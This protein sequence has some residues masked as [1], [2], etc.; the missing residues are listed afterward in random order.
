MVLLAQN[1]PGMQW[2]P[3]FWFLCFG[4]IAVGLLACV[5]SLFFPRS[6]IG[7]TTGR[8]AVGWG[9]CTSVLMTILLHGK[10]YWWAILCFAIPVIL[11]LIALWIRKL[12]ESSNLKIGRLVTGGILGLL[13]AVGLFFWGRSLVAGMQM[14]QLLG[15]SESIRVVE[16]EIDGQ[17]RRVICRDRKHCDYMTGAMRK[18]KAEMA[19]GGMSYSLRF[20]FSSGLWYTVVN[21]CV[22]PKGLTPSIPEAYPP[23]VGMSTHSIM[24]Q[25]PIPATIQEAW[26]FLW[27][28]P[29][30]NVAGRVMVIEEGDIVRWEYDPVLDREK[31]NVKK[32]TQ[33]GGREK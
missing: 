13:L 1:F 21:G 30:E 23:E 28:E 29:C 31:R 3:L 5:G 6:G 15:G 27:N 24:L 19:T 17:Q 11:G 9:I 18:A 26:S 22:A 20:K 8:A 12:K 32:F 7:S 33:I 16:F 2:I 14:I 4:G 25:E 10:L